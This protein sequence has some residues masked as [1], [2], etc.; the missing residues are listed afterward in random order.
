MA[1]LGSA[2]VEA[3]GA[4]GSGRLDDNASASWVSRVIGKLIPIYG[5]ASIGAGINIAFV[6]ALSAIPFTAWKEGGATA[7]SLRTAGAS[8]D[9]VV[10]RPEADALV[11]ATSFS[12]ILST[13]YAARVT[14]AVSCNLPHPMPGQRWKRWAR[15]CFAVTLLLTW[16]CFAIAY[17]LPTTL[18][19]RIE[20][21]FLDCLVMLGS[22]SLAILV[23]AEVMKFFERRSLGRAQDYLDRQ[24]EIGGG[25]NHEVQPEGGSSTVKSILQQLNVLTIGFITLGCE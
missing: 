12:F 4:V 1:L 15:V 23:T 7:S 18:G 16:L 3:E 8:G 20:F 24:R 5:Y 6:M 11:W 19:T 2:R 17:I 13:V 10:Q 9:V 21:Y 22:A 14:F 25:H